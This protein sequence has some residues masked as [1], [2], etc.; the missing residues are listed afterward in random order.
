MIAEVRKSSVEII[1]QYKPAVSKIA[2]QPQHK[3]LIFRSNPGVLY[4]A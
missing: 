1:Q 2:W 3:D 4:R